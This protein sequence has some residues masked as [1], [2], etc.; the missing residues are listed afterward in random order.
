MKKKLLIVTPYI[1]FPLNGGGYIAQY[2]FLEHLCNDYDIT[3]LSEAR[4]AAD[5]ENLQGLKSSIPNINVVTHHHLKVE[6]E[7]APFRHRINRFKKY[8]QKKLA[9]GAN[10]KVDHNHVVSKLTFETARPEFARFILNHLKH[11]HYD[12]L[13]LE[14]FNTLNLLLVLPSNAKKIFVHHE[15]YYK[16][17]SMTSQVDT[18]LC[19]YLVDSARYYEHTMIQLADVVVVF[20]E[21]DKALLSEVHKNVITSPFGIPEPLIIKKDASS[22]YEK[23][24]FLGGESHYPNKEGLTWF[25]DTIYI[26]NYNTI[27]WPVYVLGTWSDQ[28]KMKYNAYH[29]IVF[30]GFVGH[31][32]SIYDGAVM[33]TP[34]TSG[35]G[36]RTKIL[37]AF[38]NKVPVLSTAFAAEG[39]YESESDK[40]LLF[41]SDEKSFI[42]VYDEASRNQK[43]LQ[44]VAVSGYQHFIEY[45]EVQKLVALRKKAYGE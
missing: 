11:H 38:A 33:I 12:F 41:F 3:L 16:R 39:L 24:I 17:L 43:N 30:T 22:K 34:I 40:H 7:P 20:N 26:P 32:N 28:T 18:E 27:Q 21:D 4:S 19:Q 36:I 45:F 9:S 23:F 8:I 2:Y 5:V 14:F 44:Q 6:A 35:S 1:P 37:Q 31:L 29:R 10:P 15:L 13:Q 42:K 25:L